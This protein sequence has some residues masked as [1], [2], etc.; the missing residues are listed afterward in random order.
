MD[1]RIGDKLPDDYEPDFGDQREDAAPQPARDTEVS[2]QERTT[3]PQAPQP[4]APQQDEDYKQRSAY[5]FSPR[6][7]KPEEAPP[8]PQLKIG[9]KLPDDYKPDFA[10][11]EKKPEEPLPGFLASAY[12]GFRHGVGDNPENFAGFADTIQDLSG[13]KPGE[14]NRVADALRSAG[15]TIGGSSDLQSKGII[16]AITSG[17]FSKISNTLGED[18]GSA[19]GFLS[20]PVGAKYLGGVGGA[21]I[22]GGETAA[23]TAAAGPEVAV[24]GA[25]AG[26]VAGAKTGATTA[27]TAYNVA[28]GVGMMRNSLMEDP[29]IAKAVEDG[30]MTRRQLGIY[31]AAGGAILGGLMEANSQI[32]F[33]SAGAASPLA[34]AGVDQAK[35]L[36]AKAI[37]NAVARNVASNA[38]LTSGDMALQQVVSEVTNSLA[39]GSKDFSQRL[40]SIGEAGLTGLVTAPFLHAAFGGFAEKHEQTTGESKDQ[41]PPGTP[42]ADSD[43][44]AGQPGPGTGGGDTPLPPTGAGPTSGDDHAKGPV[45]VVQPGTVPADIV[46]ARSPPPSP[47]TQAV[48][49]QPSTQGGA[50][51]HDEDYDVTEEGDTPAQRAAVEAHNQAIDAARTAPVADG[52]DE[53]AAIQARSPQQASSPAAQPGAA[54]APATGAAPVAQPAASPSAPAAPTGLLDPAIKQQYVERRL[55]A[56]SAGTQRTPG[57]LGTR[58]RELG[59]AAES[60][61]RAGVNPLEQL[62]RQQNRGPVP[63]PAAEPTIEP[64]GQEAAFGISTGAPREEIAQEPAREAPAAAAPVAA[65]VAET[66]P[67]AA[68]EAPAPGAK[69]RRIIGIAKARGAAK[70]AEEAPVETP[71]VETPPVET[72]AEKI[73]RLKAQREA[74]REAM[75]VAPEHEE[76]AAKPLDIAALKAQR[77]A[78]RALLARKGKVEEAPEP[79][80][81]PSETPVQKAPAAEIVKKPA[82]TPEKKPVTAPKPEQRTVGET[83]I[84]GT[85]KPA[86]PTAVNKALHNEILGKMAGSDAAAS[87]QFHEAARQIAEEK[88]ATYNKSDPPAKFVRETAKDPSTQKAVTDRVIQ[89]EDKLEAQEKAEAAKVATQREAEGEAQQ[90]Q[91]QDIAAARK[92]GEE[93]GQQKA[94]AGKGGVKAA[95]GI[96]LESDRTTQRRAEA[97]MAK[98]ED[99]RNPDLVDYH[100]MFLDKKALKKGDPERPKIEKQMAALKQEMVDKARKAEAAATEKGRIAKVKA[101]EEEARQARIAS[102]KEIA[103]PIIRDHLKTLPDNASKG[104]LMSWV[105][106]L[107]TKLKNA[108]ADT[109]LE[110]DK[111]T[112]TPEQNFVAYARTAFEPRTMEKGDKSRKVYVGE[113]AHGLAEV[114]TA[115]HLIETGHVADFNEYTG[116]GDQQDALDSAKKF[117]FQEHVYRADEEKEP[118]KRKQ[119]SEMFGLKKPNFTWLKSGAETIKGK[120]KQTFKFQTEDATYNIATDQHTTV[121]EALD[122]VEKNLSWQM[123]G[124]WSIFRKMH[125]K[126]LQRMVGDTP[127]VFISGETMQKIRGGNEPAGMHVQPWPSQLSK[128]DRG[129]IF[130]NRDYFNNSSEIGKAHLLMH[131]ITHAATV[132]AVE[133]NFRGTRDI[134]NKMMNKL[135]RQ[136]DDDGINYNDLPQK[137][138]YAFT[139][140]K[141]FVAEAYSNREFQDFLRTYNIDPRFAESIG[142]PSNRAPTWWGLFRSAVQ[143]ALSMVGLGGRGQ[144]YMDAILDLHPDVM[145]STREQQERSARDFIGDDPRSAEFS[146]GGRQTLGNRA[147]ESSLD[148]MPM[149]RDAEDRLEAN[150]L[151]KVGGRMGAL[152]RWMTKYMTT[153]EIGRQS[154]NHLGGDNPIHDQA[155]NLLMSDT[156]AH[157]KSQK[158]MI[159]AGEWANFAHKNHVEAD[160][161]TDLMIDSANLRVHG[162][163]AI[164]DPVQNVSKK[165]KRDIP[166]REGWKDLNQRYNALSPEAREMYDRVG[167]HFTEQ[168]NEINTATVHNIVDTAID[169]KQVTLPTGMTREDLRDWFLRGEANKPSSDRDPRYDE[170]MAATG[171][172]GKMLKD[173][174]SLNKPNGYYVP[175]QRYGQYYTSGRKELDL[176][177]GATRGDPTSDHDTFIFSDPK[178]Q[179]AYLKSNRDIIGQV[180]TRTIDPRTGERVI[181]PTDIKYQGQKLDTQHIVR[182]VNKVMEMHDDPA[183]LEAKKAEYEK[184]GY[185]MSN[186]DQLENHM[187]SSS[188][189][190]PMQIQSL[191]RHIEQSKKDDPLKEAMK[192]GVMDAY[193]RSMANGRAAHRQLKRANILGQ[194]RDMTRIFRS[195][196]Q[197]MGRHLANLEMAPK[198]G[199]TDRAVKKLFEDRRFEKGKSNLLIRSLYDEV[200]ARMKAGYGNRDSTNIGSRLIN[201]ALTTSFLTH[202]A[203]PFYSV[204]NATQPWI[205]AMPALAG[206]HGVGRTMKNMTRALHDLGALSTY[207][208]G[209]TQTAKE[210]AHLMT[211]V[212]DVWTQEWSPQRQALSQHQRMVDVLQ[213]NPNLKNK[214]LKLEAMEELRKLGFAADNGSDA[215]DMTEVGK[216][217]LEITANRMARVARMMPEAIESVNRASTLLAAI[218]NAKEAGMGDAEAKKFAVSMTEA[219]QGGYSAANNPR[220]FNTPAGK[221][222]FQF[223]KF[224]LMYGQLYYKSIIGSMPGRGTPESRAVA[225]KT[226][227]GLTLATTAIAGIAGNPPMELARLAVTLMH[228]LGFLNDDWEDDEN[229]LQGGI[230]NILSLMMDPKTAGT[231]AE[232]AMRGLPR[233]ARIDMSNQLSNSSMLFFGQ[234]KKADAADTALW[235]GEQLIG[236]PGQLFVDAARSIA[237]RDM[238]MLPWPKF[239]KDAYSGY[240][241]ATTQ[242]TSPTGKPYGPKPSGWDVPAALQTV[243]GAKP[244]RQSEQYE[245]GAG[246]G[247]GYEYKQ[248]QKQKQERTT[249]MQQWLNADP[250]DRQQIWHDVIVPYNQDKKGKERIEQKDLHNSLK[251]RETDVRKQAREGATP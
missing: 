144:N 117:P 105:K 199:A 203:S 190:M 187:N 42:V 216:S 150:R 210:Y 238:S 91:A 215:P 214:Q 156:L 61:H 93:G 66:A 237:N 129:E 186:V 102:N 57:Q 134:I 73:Q 184:L 2:R 153:E 204:A 29:T 28:A 69:G 176:P 248:Q 228:G 14:S 98:P 64:A 78:T 81:A 178:K 244:A 128:G 137:L 195:N 241:A 193:I 116:H 179:E 58:R 62:D 226:L 126:V 23:E 97:E 8:A 87:D 225:R 107:T 13:A 213:N 221:I 100:N 38:L 50:A 165:G 171:T 112:Q 26:A 5:D 27:S 109:P 220:I 200:K 77:E 67:A 118:G 19:F 90:K 9:D 92:R 183:D 46:A 235:A 49:A 88:A 82:P 232:A 224:A 143:N 246:K 17:S 217:K 158:G 10:E 231:A 233:L 70:A 12:H 198:I 114:A 16:D 162:G 30:K 161:L 243:L 80:A 212:K 124:P 139:N 230:A 48:A 25:V 54:A 222:A 168:K 71:P 94:R 127:I 166:R 20:G 138:R 149:M 185:K 104:Q 110:F 211:H 65:P 122:G 130:I 131:E 3:E 86:A 196:A 164:T 151:Q 52:T 236:A 111:E 56:E 21:I 206:H 170:I 209:V 172:T 167:Q 39:G 24:P 120:P 47:N 205:V 201:S 45:E 191:L 135:K 68:P 22:G 55:A 32:L 159:L 103:P 59:N 113:R 234:P 95:E 194:S 189:L 197:V 250:K 99:Q 208:T 15:K 76:P 74:T 155:R 84:T 43:Q 173:M 18:L 101:A 218:D 181:D 44:Q 223:K 123:K 89:L 37:S 51:V 148:F 227:A 31:S 121:A 249:T 34:K 35:A 96:A 145:M 147:P 106:G 240:Q 132:F 160:K 174:M 63:E 188:D 229:K 133:H 40:T 141:E 36:M 72:P 119:M 83:V 163:R 154:D 207:G 152:R 177:D 1:L 33:N 192:R 136:L 251:R 108:G 125:N 60:L 115:R 79:A 41:T 6:P 180:F 247:S 75:R 4:A 242:K 157:D 53:A 7:G 142:L 182:S 11:E 219:T 239:M 202:L 169:E 85:Q 146:L 175:A 140:E 245:Y